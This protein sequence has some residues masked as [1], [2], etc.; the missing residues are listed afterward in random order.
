MAGQKEFLV[1]KELKKNRTLTLFQ[2]RELLN[3]PST[4]KNVIKNMQLKGLI[5][6]K[7]NQIYITS[8][9]LKEYLKK[10]KENL[11]IDFFDCFNLSRR[12]SSY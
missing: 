1:L 7:D 8:K 11:S 4:A 2:V 3:Y 9:G 5:E 6:I 12:Y 10:Y